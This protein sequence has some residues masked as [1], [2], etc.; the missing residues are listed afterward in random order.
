MP[1]KLT[2]QDLLFLRRLARSC[3]EQVTLPRSLLATLLDNR[4]GFSE[5][6][7]RGGEL[8][9]QGNALIEDLELDNEKLMARLAG[10]AAWCRWMAPILKDW[11]RGRAERN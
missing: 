2:E 7:R 1:E 3:D 9:A 4:D 11:L 5:L 8:L 6:A 10:W